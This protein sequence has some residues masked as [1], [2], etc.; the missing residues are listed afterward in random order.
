LEFFYKWSRNADQNAPFFMKVALFDR[1]KRVR[2]QEKRRE[3]KNVQNKISISSSHTF[4]WHGH[5]ILGF[6]GRG[7]LA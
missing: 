6:E 1:D 3:E 5:H 2:L 7:L 4:F